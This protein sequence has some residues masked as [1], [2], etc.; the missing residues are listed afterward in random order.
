M[1]TRSRCTTGSWRESSA[2]RS[3]PGPASQRTGQLARLS[4]DGTRNY[5]AT[6]TPNLINGND[7]SDVNF[8]VW[9]SLN[10]AMPR[11]QG[12]SAL[13]TA[14]QAISDTIRMV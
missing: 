3:D 13:P 5:A 11:D 1:R 7:F 12:Y 6:S 2:D 9:P 4:Q 14:S 8:P 10:I